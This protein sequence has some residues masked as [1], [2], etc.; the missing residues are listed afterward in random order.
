MINIVKSA[1]LPLCD[2][3]HMVGSSD[4]IFSTSSYSTSWSVGTELRPSVMSSDGCNLISRFSPGAGSFFSSLLASQTTG[5][6]VA[7]ITFAWMVSSK[8]SHKNDTL[9]LLY[10]EELSLYSPMIRILRK[11]FT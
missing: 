10:N 8:I 6:P 7:L 3:N 11:Y 5:D 2:P 4:S 9:E 1:C